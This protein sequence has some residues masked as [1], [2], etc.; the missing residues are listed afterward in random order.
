MLKQLMK[1]I[2]MH[3]KNL[4]HLHHVNFE[5]DPLTKKQTMNFIHTS[6]KFTLNL[7]NIKNR[8]FLQ[9]SMQISI[10][11]PSNFQEK[12]ILSRKFRK[13]QVLS[14]VYLTHEYA[15]RLHFNQI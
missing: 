2:Q 11:S 12:P 6:E 10:F 15:A 9:S 1:S 13:S 5:C 8:L 14:Q 7:S 3:P 4:F